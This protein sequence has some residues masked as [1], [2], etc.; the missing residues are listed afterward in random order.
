M[1]FPKTRNHSYF[2]GAL[3][4]ERGKEGE[5]EREGER[6]RARVRTREREREKKGMREFFM[7]NMFKKS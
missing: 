4:K 6:A 7:C 3:L 5:R 2:Y 1:D